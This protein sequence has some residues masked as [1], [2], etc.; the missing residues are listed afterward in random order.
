MEGL[1]S[2]KAGKKALLFYMKGLMGDLNEIATI[3]GQTAVFAVNS[4]K[5]RTGLGSSEL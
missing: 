5:I 2:V 4:H 3:I 1:L